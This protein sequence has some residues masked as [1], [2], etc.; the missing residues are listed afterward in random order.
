METN[1]KIPN[2][3]ERFIRIVEKRVN[4]IL[5]NLDSLGNCSNKR[6]YEYSEK[7]VKL[8]FNEI[9]KK[10][11]ETKGKF[12]GTSYGKSSFRLTK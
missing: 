1:T 9:E 7:D 6:N 5:Q 3:R 8:I 12:E 4:N 10:V 2:K 11:K